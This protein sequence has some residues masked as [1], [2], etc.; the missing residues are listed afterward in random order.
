MGLQRHI[1]VLGIFSR[2]WL[3]DG[4]RTYLGDLPRVLA[5]TRDVL[6]MH[7]D[8]PALADFR[9]WLEAEVLPR[10]RSQSWYRA[11]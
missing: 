8:I 7:P 1:K 2:L 4:K 9:H 3:R 6:A 11:P 10:A 5:Y